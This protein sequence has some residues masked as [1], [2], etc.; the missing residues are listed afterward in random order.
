M[1]KILLFKKKLA[2]EGRTLQIRG[3]SPNLLS[4]FQMINFDSL[5]TIKQ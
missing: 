3:C 2:E 5:V 1:G 4:L